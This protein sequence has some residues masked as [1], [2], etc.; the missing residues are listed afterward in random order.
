[1]SLPR[2]GRLTNPPLKSNLYDKRKD[3]FNVK[4]WITYLGELILITA[5][6]GLL[7]HIVPE[8]N[9]KKH[10][11]FVIS[12]CVLVALAVPMFSMVMEFPEIFEQSFEEVRLEENISSEQ[13][14]ES[15]ISVSKKEIETAIVS[16]ISEFYGISPADISVETVL[17]SENPEAIEISRI[18]VVLRDEGADVGAIRRTLDDLF[19]G[20]SE[21]SVS[22][23][24][25]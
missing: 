2:W 21:V 19:L 5:V 24:K 1:M 25:P 8:G 22:I 14:T 15:L 4:E 16:Y 9:M 17:N 6:S 13:L 12:L 23:L 3:D 7:S 11:Q 18:L 10:L 20:K